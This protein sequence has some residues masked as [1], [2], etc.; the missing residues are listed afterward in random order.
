MTQNIEQRTLA[1]TNTM[2]TAA[3]SVDEIAHKDADVVTPVGTRKSFPKIS[4]EW[5]EKATEL[6]TIWENDSANL[7]QDWQN[8]R[9]E[10]STKAL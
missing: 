3:K 10:L 8:E 4:R 5:D 2:E 6:K 1:A 9:N 7:R